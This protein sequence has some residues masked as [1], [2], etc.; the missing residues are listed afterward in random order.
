MTRERTLVVVNYH[1][2]ELTRR[3]IESARAASSVPLLAVVV[4]NSD[5]PAERARL[6]GAGADIVIDAPDNPGYGEGANRGAAV[7]EGPILI[8]SNPDVVFGSGSIDLLA[9]G[10]SDDRVAMTGPRFSWDA[11]GRWLL[12]PPDFPTRA[13]EIDR[14]LAG[15]SALWSR[16]WRRRRQGQR[17]RFW[18]TEEASSV[19]ALSGAVLC[20]RR[21]AFD[22]AGGFDAGFR[23]YFEEIDLMARL[24]DA[25]WG[26]LHLPGA[27][28]HHLYN[29]SAGRTATAAERYAE[30]EIRFLTKRY[31]SR[32]AR[33]AVS[34][35]GALEAP[36]RFRAVERGTTLM[37]PRGEWLIEA[38]PLRDFATT[39]GS[40]TE[41]GAI[42]I[43]SGI[44]SGFH[45]TSLFV[46]ATD[47]TTGE[48][49]EA[50]EIKWGR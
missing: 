1:S 2:A 10:L 7:A 6:D 24:R 31:G 16:W 34:R 28:C 35:R 11:E 13:R 50:V 44:L 8:V 9:Q 43:P 22:E 21:K 42:E 19:E 23:L 41:G 27:R 14:V 29:Q 36:I 40:F 5:D 20:I 33:W 48:A 30:S 38:S 17:I 25:R 46:M 26:L 18:R 15:R 12:P 49:S 39:A 37:L 3:A 45:G 4:D 47:L 32:F